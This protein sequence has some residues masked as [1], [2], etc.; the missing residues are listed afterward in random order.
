MYSK[1]GKA[2]RLSSWNTQ[3]YSKNLCYGNDIRERIGLI[4]SFWIIYMPGGKVVHPE[5]DSCMGE[6]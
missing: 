4:T 3:K 6:P 5:A 2:E 1:K